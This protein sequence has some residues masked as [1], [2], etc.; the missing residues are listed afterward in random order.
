MQSQGDV[1]IQPVPENDLE[2]EIL[3]Y[4]VYNNVYFT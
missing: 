3:A 4:G 2:P 1:V